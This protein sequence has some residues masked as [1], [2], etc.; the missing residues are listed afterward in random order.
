[1]PYIKI[2]DC[3]EC[4]EC[5]VSKDYTED[6]FEHCEKWK[7]KAKDKYIVRYKD[8]YEKN[9]PVPKWCPKRLGEKHGKQDTK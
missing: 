2:A 6:S 9:P 7:C 3:T 1:M 5:V 4:R 8:W